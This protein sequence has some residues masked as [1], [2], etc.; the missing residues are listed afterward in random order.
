MA[1]LA[2]A[3][4]K[5]SLIGENDRTHDHLQRLQENSLRNIGNNSCLYMS[6][7]FPT[8]L[9]RTVIYG[10]PCGS[11]QMPHCNL[12]V[13]FLKAVSSFRK[14]CRDSPVVKVD[15]V[16]HAVWICTFANNQFE[17]RN[18]AGHVLLGESL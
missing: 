9:K 8:S 17:V 13:G 6:M 10:L 11:E 7:Y 5:I 14:S 18:T 12:F 3:M 1:G 16:R 4:L 15:K 2:L